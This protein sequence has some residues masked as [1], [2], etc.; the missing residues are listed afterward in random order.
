MA[1]AVRPGRADEA[2]A[3]RAIERA[4]GQLFATV[5]HP[6]IAAHEPT[7]AADLQDAARDGLL[8]VA[9]G[10]DDRPAGF[11]L[12]AELDGCL[13]VHELSVHPAH[14]GQRL[15]VPLFNAAEAIARRRGL[16]ALTL[17]TFRAV[18]WNAPYYARLGFAEMPE[19]GP[20]LRIVI[21]RQKAAG[22]DIA[23]RVAMR[24]PLQP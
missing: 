9:A 4:A 13:Y 20:G 15:A 21:A 2:E 17:T 22:L 18:P 23:A 3:I 12:A 24:R 8:L 10:D 6:E 7:P 1:Y 14:A 11:L 5:G 19:P 16:A